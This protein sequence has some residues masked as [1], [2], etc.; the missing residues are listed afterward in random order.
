MD[1]HKPI[2]V[3]G[4]HRSGTTWIGRMLAEEPSLLYIH[5]PFSV[6]DAPSRG[7][8]NTEFKYWFTYITRENESAYYKPL[9]NTI[10]LKYDL[11]G[12][13]KTYRSK[14]GLRELFREY[15][16]FLRNR[17]KGAIALIKDPMAFF[18]AKWL[19]ER[20]DMQ[21]VMV[22]RHPAAFVS[23]IKKLNWRH[24]LSHFLEQPAL[25]RERLYP[26]A[27]EL[28]DYASKEHD[29]IDQAILLWKLIHYTMTQYREAHKNWIFVRHEDLSRNPVEGFRKLYE[30]LGLEFSDEVQRV[31]ETYS[32][33][34]NP[35]ETDAPVGSEE[36]LIRD[37]TS[38]IWN[39]KKRL[40]ASEIGKIREEVEYIS[41]GFYSNEDW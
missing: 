37:S 18:S 9:R 34:K 22:I 2:L 36:I 16:S 7:I 28:R 8:C 14:E 20:F 17:R 26:F 21:V 31:I 10:E 41:R 25:M 15:L 24:P 4:S 3:T 6:T 19:A 29:L 38:N 30:G 39:W 40:P 23:S 32:N 11:A 12:G 5:E 33:S 35:A 27:G 13:L 1:S